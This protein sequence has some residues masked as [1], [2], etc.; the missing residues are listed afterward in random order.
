MKEDNKYYW[1]GIEEVTNSPSFVK[2]ADKE[3]PEGPSEAEVNS[4]GSSRRDFLKT[5][6]FSI[7]A[8]SLA[9]CEAPVRKAIPYVEKPED[10]DPGLPNYYASSYM[11]GGDY[12]SVVVKTREGRPIKIE[13][14]KLSK[15]TRGKTSSHVEASVLSLYDTERITAPE[16][17]GNKSSWDDVDAAVR[18]GLAAANGNIRVVSNTVISPSTQAAIDG[19][20]AAYPGAQH[21]QYDAVSMAGILDAHKEAY[22]MRALPSY[23]FSK[24]DVIA[25]FGADFLGNWGSSLINANR[26]AEGRKLN[27]DKRDMSRHYQWESNMTLTGANADYRTPVLSSAIPGQVAL[28]YNMVAAKTGNTPV[29]TGGAEAA[30]F[31][32]KAAA[33]LLAARG[34]SLVVCGFNDKDIQVLVA[35][36]N[37]ML[38][39]YGGTIDIKRPMLTRQGDDLKMD[40][41][42]KELTGGRVGA[43]IFFNCNPVYDHPQ[44]K[45]IGE[46]LAG[47]GL[48]VATNATK[49]E[50]GSLVNIAAPDHHYLESWNDAMPTPGHLSLVQPTITPIFDTRQAGESFLR[51]S[52]QNTD[53]YTFLSGR[54]QRNVYSQD[55]VL[56]D[57]QSFWDRCLHDGVYEMSSLANGDGGNGEEAETAVA[58][59]GANPTGAAQAIASRYSGASGTELII[60]EKHG[61]GTG[62]MANNPW[63]QE[64]P[65]GITKVTWGNYVTISM[66]LANE[67]GLSMFE[68]ET[69]YLNVTVNGTTLKLPA[70]VQPGQAR[71]TIGIALGYGRTKAGKVGNGVGVDVYPML[72]TNGGYR[73]TLITGVQVAD[74]GEA[75]ALARTQ[76]HETVMARTNVVQESTHEEYKKNP[77]AGRD[78]VMIETYAGPEKPT[79]ISLWKGHKYPNHHWGLMIDMNSCT[80]CGSC[81]VACNVENNVP[82]VGKQEVINRREMHWLR[83]DRYYSSDA[84]PEDKKAL[85]QAAENPEVTFQPM[86]CQHCNNAPCETV[87]PVLATTHSTEGLNQMTYNRCVGTRYCANNCPYK[88]RRFNWFKYHDN[89][90]FEKNLAMS[91]DLGKMVLNPDVTVRARGVMEKCSMCVQRIQAGKLAAKRERRKLKD[92]DIEMA[93]ESS[94][95]TNAIMFGDMNDPSSRISK[96]L[97]VE[98]NERGFHVLDELNVQ[99]NVTY[100]RK[101]R[102][103]TKAEA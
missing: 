1:K 52:G 59:T 96:A 25:G 55:V 70:L 43:V 73:G 23:D 34:R 22:G 77:A 36:I 27:K 88:V 8:V 79:N 75:A 61:I 49:D 29:G 6:G 102:N 33:D 100:L 44:G 82:V 101:I 67:I 20:L 45:A 48:T 78:Q 50:T 3:F 89:S 38:G 98:V 76:T 26:Y 40:A 91:S 87:C 92:G 4:G 95:P 99:S 83:I 19:L 51:W 84:R 64:L 69:R 85:E 72:P 86:M 94:C 71:G 7:A 93:C 63:L 80:G 12:C 46:A 60:Y 66:G 24:A 16:I 39:N 32:E 47:V 5:M 90:K 13:G 57:F 103:K 15:L 68:E 21:I 41:F 81:I 9:A 14:N 53:F 28:L 58:S 42:V 62:A 10:V 74:T 54:W 35:G 17:G 56:S 18:S 65:D 30:P 11:E 97:E 2:H 37:E 31:L